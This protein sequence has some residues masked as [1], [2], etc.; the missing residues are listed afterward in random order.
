MA[1]SGGSDSTAAAILTHKAVTQNILDSYITVSVDHAT[2]PDSLSEARAA[3]RATKGDVLS[4][5]VT[6]KTMEHARMLRYAVLAE[7]AAKHGLDGIITGHTKDDVAES[8]LLRAGQASGLDGL[9]S[10]P[11]VSPLLALPSD[12][13]D[14]RFQVGKD[15]GILLIRPLLHATRAELEDVLVE[16]GVQRGDWVHD[17]ANRDTKYTRVRARMALSESSHSSSSSG[18][19]DLVDS[20]AGVANVLY[21]VRSDADAAVRQFIDE[22]TTTTVL[23]GNDNDSTVYLPRDKVLALPRPLATRVLSSIVQEVGNRTYPPRSQAISRV[24]NSSVGSS[25]TLVRVLVRTNPSTFTISP[26]PS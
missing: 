19:S 12:L 25:S 7:Y 16:S 9:A 15:T 21:G 1:V 26:Q 13:E 22:N 18:S 14:R 17:P 6:P 20:L 23:G 2:R 5:P 8:F 11:P 10:M 4:L 3:V 24:L